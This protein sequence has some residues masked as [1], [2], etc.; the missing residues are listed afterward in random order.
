MTKI[1]VS[2][3]AKAVVRRNT[4]GLILDGGFIDNVSPMKR[5]NQTRTN[6]INRLR[7]R[8]DFPAF[9]DTEARS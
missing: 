6:V 9:L 4:E 7:I 5:A 3:A 1:S 2:E 8:Q